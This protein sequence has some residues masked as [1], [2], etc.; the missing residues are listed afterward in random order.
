MVSPKVDVEAILTEF[1][2]VSVK[3]WLS[4]DRTQVYLDTEQVTDPS[5]DS[6][7]PNFP[8]NCITVKEIGFG[9]VGLY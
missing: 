5:W 4:I 1:E 8:E 6:I 3:I 2:K 7:W 9:T